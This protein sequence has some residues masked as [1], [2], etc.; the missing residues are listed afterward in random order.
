M[1]FSYLL[2]KH[3]IPL[4]IGFFSLFPLILYLVLESGHGSQVAV[5]LHY[6]IVL[7]YAVPVL[8]SRTSSYGYDYGVKDLYYSDTLSSYA[9]A[10]LWLGI[11]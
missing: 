3:M 1:S 10:E 11:G 9:F 2:L 4:C 8:A 7:L 5:W 6:S